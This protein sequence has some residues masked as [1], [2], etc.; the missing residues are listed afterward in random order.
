MA[1]Y[2]SLTTEDLALRAR[3][4]DLDAF[5]EIITRFHGPLT[6]LIGATFREWGEVEE[7]EQEVLVRVYWSL[8]GAYDADRPFWPW[9]RQIA[10]NTV[11]ERLREKC[12]ESQ[13]RETL[14]Q[15]AIVEEQ[16]RRTEREQAGETLDHLETC[17]ERLT[18]RA[19]HTVELYYREGIPC[20]G[21]AKT[22][23]MSAAAVRMALKRTRE[24]LRDCISGLIQG[25]PSA[26][27]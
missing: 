1:E 18:A 12:R 10:V 5:D 2:G 8:S 9:L 23:D 19:R 11:R 20:D 22:L 26:T 15:Q 13:R 21:I 25:Q 14:I 7:L 3:S 6:R 17:M 27:T 24:T 4:K 16:A